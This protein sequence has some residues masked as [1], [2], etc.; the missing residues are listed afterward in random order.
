MLVLASNSPRRRQ[1]LAASGLEFTVLPAPVDESD[2]PGE[3]PQA[4]VLRL[5]ETKARA[6]QHAWANSSSAAGV[7]FL[8]AD[9]TVVVDGEILG[10]PD[11]P[12]QAWRML[13]RLRDRTHQVLTAIALVRH[14]G[15]ECIKD[16]AVSQV[17]MRSYTDEEIAAYVDEGD[18]LDKAG[19]YAIQHVE[20][21]PV[22]AVEGCYANVMG[23]PVC[24]LAVLLQECGMN[25]LHRPWLSCQAVTGVPCQVYQNL[26]A[27]AFPSYE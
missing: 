17:S 7:L 8:G 27:E 18:P 6:A 14:P 12:A 2:R 5:A 16:V 21:H 3:T 23:L 9:T 22:S 13:Q 20:F 25:R 19:A 4:Y 10:K 24:R 1:L 11:S 15:D 26:M